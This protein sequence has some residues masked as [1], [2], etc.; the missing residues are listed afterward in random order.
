MNQNS[1][2]SILSSV[3]F[4]SNWFYH[5][6]T[7]VIEYITEQLKYNIICLILLVRKSVSRNSRVLIEVDGVSYLLGLILALV[8]KTFK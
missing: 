6:P 4:F 1:P 7:K 3:I 8:I 2:K 5:P